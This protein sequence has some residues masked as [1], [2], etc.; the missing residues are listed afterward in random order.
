MNIMYW[1]WQN[2]DVYENQ[3]WCRKHDPSVARATNSLAANSA[4]P[5]L[6]KAS[7]Q[8]TNTLLQSAFRGSKYDKVSLD[9]KL[10]AQEE[11]RQRLSGLRLGTAYSTERHT[12]H[13][14]SGQV[15]TSGANLVDWQAKIWQ[16]L[17][18]S[19][20]RTGV[21]ERCAVFSAKSSFEGGCSPFC[22]QTWTTVPP[23]APRNAH[24]ERGI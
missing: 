21:P 10:I 24:V 17:V 15:I 16:K 3:W 23:I 19:F 13:R 4:Q 8:A 5:Q 7:Q 1:M 18:V 6:A 2:W 20:I 11:D 9:W 14:I 22:Q 12:G